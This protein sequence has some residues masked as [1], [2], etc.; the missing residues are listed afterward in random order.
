MTFR[1]IILSIVTIFSN[2]IPDVVALIKGYKNMCVVMGNFVCVMHAV[3]FQLHVGWCLGF[4][5]AITLSI[6]AI[7]FNAIP[8]VVALTKHYKNMCS[9]MGNFGCVMHAVEFQVHVGLVLRLF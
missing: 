2:A 4:F 1:A 9:I 7:F 6:M 3:E 5:S 8:D